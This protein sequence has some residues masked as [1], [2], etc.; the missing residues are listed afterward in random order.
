MGNLVATPEL[1]PAE[2][3]E[4]Q[5]TRTT[6]I[7]GSD[8]AAIVG[9]SP[10]AGRFDVYAS[11]VHGHT[12]DDNQAMRWGRVLEPV[13]ATE[14]ARDH[15]MCVISAPVTWRSNSR[16]WAIANVDRFVLTESPFDRSE[17]LTHP[18]LGGLLSKAELLAEC[19]RMLEAGDV[20]VLEVKTTGEWSADRWVDDNGAPKVPD[21]YQIQV[22]HYLDVLGL[23]RAFV[24]VLIGGRDLRSV[25]VERDDDA[26]GM[27][28][29]VVDWFWHEHI[30]ARVEPEA[31][32]LARDTLKS[33][34]RDVV[35]DDP[36][37]LPPAARGFV[38][39]RAALKA[40]QKA[41]DEQ[42]DA[43]DARFMQWLKDRTAGVLEDSTSGKPAVTWKPQAGRPDMAAIRADVEFAAI[44]EQFAA[45]ENKHRRP[46]SRVLRFARGGAR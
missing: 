27:I 33:M 8:V 6:G 36:V 14:W 31:D 17:T 45:L 21:Y 38:E 40:E 16:P 18:D 1:A 25:P 2:Y 10:W 35:D 22:Q 41:L 4:W 42:I 3:E 26:I 12:I 15:D 11:K 20:A 29:E 30:V 19:A 46:D 13:V 39:T 43:I 7:G 37:V 34:Y 9:L 23:E 44:A 5:Q 28:R 24:A 32:M